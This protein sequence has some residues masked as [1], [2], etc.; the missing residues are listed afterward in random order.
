MRLKWTASEKEDNITWLTCASAIGL[1]TGSLAASTIVQIGRRKAIILASI[2][3]LIGGLMQFI[4]NFWLIF[5]GKIVYGASAAVMLTACALYLSE[6]LPEEKVGTHGFAVNF[7]VTIGISIVLNLGIAVS[8][9]NEESKSW[10]LV[11]FVPVVGA[12]VNFLLWLLWFRNE[13]IGFC[14]TNAEKSDGNYKEEAYFG[15]KR[16]YHT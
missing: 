10:L 9:D 8:K 16:L 4:F 11:A 2:V 15:I 5:A 1:M 7:G 12:I 3:A 6:T 13:P 14:I